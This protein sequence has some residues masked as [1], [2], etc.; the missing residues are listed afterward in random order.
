VIKLDNDSLQYIS[1]QDKNKI[2]AIR[3]IRSITEDF[4][5]VE[6]IYNTVIIDFMYNEN[7]EQLCFDISSTIISGE[8]VGYVKSGHDVEIESSFIYKI[9]DIIED[10][11]DKEDTVVWTLAIQ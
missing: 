11:L 9:V 5:F 1:T 7:I 4:K 6:F 8:L 10:Y 2:E 3:K